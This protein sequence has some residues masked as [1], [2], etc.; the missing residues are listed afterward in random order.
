VNDRT[1]ITAALSPRSAPQRTRP[2]DRSRL[3]VIRGLTVAATA[4]ALILGM[5]AGSG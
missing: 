3:V 5:A 1:R 2:H 4:A